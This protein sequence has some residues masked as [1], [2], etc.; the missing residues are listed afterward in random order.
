MAVSKAQAAQ[1]DS[2]LMKLF[3]TSGGQGGQ[4]D[5]GGGA[6]CTVSARAYGM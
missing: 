5:G 3:P 1:K 2:L 6:L 4:N